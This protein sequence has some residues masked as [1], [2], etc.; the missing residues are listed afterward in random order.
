MV[1]PPLYLQVPTLSVLRCNQ[2]AFQRQ[3]EIKVLLLRHRNRNHRHHPLLHSLWQTP[4]PCHFHRFTN[5]C[6]V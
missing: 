4:F 1:L 2:V 6:D 3:F 5:L